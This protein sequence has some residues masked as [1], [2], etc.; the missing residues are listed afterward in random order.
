ML[1]TFL[2]EEEVFDAIEK[3]GNILSDIETKLNDKVLERFEKE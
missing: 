3:T 1:E 2:I